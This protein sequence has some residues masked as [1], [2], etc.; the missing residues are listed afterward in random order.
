MIGVSDRQ[1]C[2]GYTNMVASTCSM[3]GKTSGHSKKQRV[4]NEVNFGMSTCHCW[5]EV[6]P[7]RALHDRKENTGLT[8]KT[9]DA[10]G[11]WNV[12]RKGDILKNRKGKEILQD[13]R[14]S[15]QV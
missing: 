7:G 15:D 14:W 5:D 8:L 12:G 3:D 6:W 10:D 1:A 4:G 2:S 11:Q 13:S 9:P